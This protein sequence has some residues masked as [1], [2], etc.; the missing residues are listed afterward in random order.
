M[1][2][3]ANASACEEETMRL[4]DKLRTIGYRRD[5]CELIAPYTLEINILKKKNNALILAHHY[6]TPDIVYGVADY[7]EDALG[8]IRR[9]E[10]SNAD[11]IIACSVTSLAEMIKIGSPEK[12]VI[13]PSTEAG[14]SVADSITV[15]EVL[16]LKARHPGAPAVAYAT[17]TAE[18]K[19][20]SD[21]IVT[22][23]N[24]RKV[25]ANIPA[26][27]ILFYPDHAFGKALQQ[28]QQALNKEIVTWEGKCVVHDNYT[29]DQVISFRKKNP[30]TAVLFHSEV[31]PSLYTYG[32]MHGG[33][34]AMK[35]YVADHPEV[36]EFFL[37]TECGLS[38]QMRVEYPGKKFIGTCSLCPF[39]KTI[40][41]E[42]ILLALRGELPPE[43][44]IHFQPEVL[45]NIQA[46]YRR[47]E[48]VA[49][50]AA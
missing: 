43:N 19:A 30:N 1:A 48:T 7:A 5:D 44:T 20:V 31:D 11:M 38:D 35:K 21:Y 15:D 9:G 8:L 12:T 32:D 47:S 25:I 42:N 17:T 45:G 4:Y 34:G 2:I 24:A 41:L 36:N 3:N 50:R 14:C 22:S 40:N 33:T 27:K 37:V 18:V 16:A 23:A 26:P 10:E 46:A 39:M 6:M 13:C 49:A 28:E 29:I